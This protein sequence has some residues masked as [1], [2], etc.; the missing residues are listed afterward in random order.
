MLICKCLCPAAQEDTIKWTDT[1]DRTDNSDS[2]DSIVIGDMN[3]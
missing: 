2:T 1:T 3:Y